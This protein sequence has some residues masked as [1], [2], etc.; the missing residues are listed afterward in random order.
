MK[1]FFISAIFVIFSLSSFS[2]NIYGYGMSEDS[3]IMKIVECFK[4]IDDR[5]VSKDDISTIQEDLS[6]LNYTLDTTNFIIYGYQVDSKVNY[7]S[8]NTFFSDN[9]MLS[10]IFRSFANVEFDYSSVYS[11]ERTKN[12]TTFKVIVSHTNNKG[13][14][15]EDIFSFSIRKGEILSL[16]IL[17][18]FPA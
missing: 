15:F 13:E 17:T 16:Q 14:K 11:K 1:T 8:H 10:N 6:S 18:N 2:Q 5:I 4:K 7:A 12:S 9:K 3:T